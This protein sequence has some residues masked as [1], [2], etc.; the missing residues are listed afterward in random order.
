MEENDYKKYQITRTE[1][2]AIVY[3]HYR[4]ITGSARVESWKEKKTR[5]SAEMTGK[6][7]S[8]DER[9]N[10]FSPPQF[11]SYVGCRTTS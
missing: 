11:A 8:K 1:L 5:L 7:W 9:E 4:L 2:Q 6:L 10:S 3:I